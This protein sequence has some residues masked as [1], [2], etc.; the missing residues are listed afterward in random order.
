MRILYF[1][2]PPIFFMQACSSIP[3]AEKLSTD[4]K[5][6]I[7]IGAN[8]S[9][10]LI[11]NASSAYPEEACNYAR[12]EIEALLTKTGWFFDLRSKKESADLVITFD[13]PNRRP[14]YTTPAHNPVFALISFAIPLWWSENFG[15]KFE[16]LC[17]K[18]DAKATIDTERK[19]IVVWWGF[20]SLFNLSQH[21]A[22]NNDVNREVESI[23][24]QLLPLIRELKKNA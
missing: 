15:Y 7:S 2:L 8:V 9:A 21:R 19:G 3:L 6:E 22:Q 11:C 18:C 4:R 14:Y 13:V 1:L 20:S 12:N 17:R 23:K 24:E 5:K 10:S 16:A